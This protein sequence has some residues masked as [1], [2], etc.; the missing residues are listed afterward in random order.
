MAIPLLA[1]VAPI[2]DSRARAAIKRMLRRSGLGDAARAW[3]RS[4]RQ[5]GRHAVRVDETLVQTYLAGHPVRRLHIG[6][7]PHLLDGWL[8]ADYE[9]KARSVLCLDATQRFPLPSDSFDTVFSEHMIEHVPHAG[10]AAMLS[11]VFRVL[12]P[13]GRVRITTPDFAFLVRLY[14]ASA[15]PSSLQRAY[16]DWA[17]ATFVPNAPQ[18]DALFVVNNYV[19]DWG[20]QFIYDERC[21]RAALI[22]AGFVDVEA[23]RLNESSDP[24]LQGVENLDRMPEG[25]LALESLTLEARKPAA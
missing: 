2:P 17:C 4:L 18:A 19:R 24:A 9:P 5:A 1:P 16:I 12:R 25:F 7:G 13:G 21:L 20:H 8:N 15:E 3:R 22:S 6:C 11:E 14:A 10:G 23:R